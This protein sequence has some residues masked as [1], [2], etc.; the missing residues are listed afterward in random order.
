[1][2]AQKQRLEQADLYVPISRARRLP[3]RPLLRAA[4]A[5]MLLMKRPQGR[6]SAKERPMNAYTASVQA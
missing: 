2:H 3:L 4:S 1:M 6:S 5:R